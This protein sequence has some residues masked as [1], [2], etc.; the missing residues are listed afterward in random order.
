MSRLLSLP[1]Q[2]RQRIWEMALLYGPADVQLLRTC[3]QI[4]VEAEGIIFRRPL[5][6]ASQNELQSWLQ[7]ISENRL[8][9]V[10]ILTLYLQDLE[11]LPLDDDLSWPSVSLLERYKRE[12]E[13]VLRALKRFPRIHSIS[14]HKP[15]TVRSYLYRDFYFS[16][17]RKIS[18]QYPAL[19]AISF[20]S[21]EH[22]L[23]FLKSFQD[24]RPRSS[25]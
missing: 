16:V 1:P 19:R 12:A 6:F 5:R 4:R 20:Y 8:P 24:L 3:Q 15:D 25:S 7:G 14:L 11:V 13:N 17:L 10:K 22:P 23:D 18:L 9:Q 2:L 21:D